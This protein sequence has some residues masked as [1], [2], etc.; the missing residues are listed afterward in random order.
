[1][2]LKIS[3]TNITYIIIIKIQRTDT[4]GKGHVL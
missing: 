3:Y 1:M 2:V 4:M